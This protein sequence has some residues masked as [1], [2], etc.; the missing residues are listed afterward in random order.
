MVGGIRQVVLEVENQD[1]ALGFWTGPMG[2]ELVYDAPYAGRRWLELRTPDRAITVTLS[3]EPAQPRSAP[4]SP[5][6]SNLFFHCNSLP[7]TYD[8]LPA[9][10][11]EN[12]SSPVLHPVAWRSTF[13]DSEGNRFALIPVNS[14]SGRG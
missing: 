1:R 11:G 4:A 5:P 9:P 10:G 8:E 3:F 12:S 6:T 7:W 2:F 14:D 13:E